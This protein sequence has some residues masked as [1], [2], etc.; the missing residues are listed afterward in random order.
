MGARFIGQKLTASPRAARACSAA[1]VIPLWCSTSIGIGHARQSTARI[2]CHQHR[3]W[4]CI[5]GLDPSRCAV[6]QCRITAGPPRSCGMSGRCSRCLW[7]RRESN[8][9][10]S[11]AISSLGNPSSPEKTSAEPVRDA[12]PLPTVSDDCERA[13]PKPASVSFNPSDVLRKALDEAIAKGD[14]EQAVKLARVLA[15]LA[16]TPKPRNVV[17]IA[18]ARKS[19]R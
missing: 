13:K 12:T 16:P 17:D 18:T 11:D 3:Y 19:R 6:L 4:M 5:D 15:T 9:A 8:L 7:R 2:E 1:G 10:E 14:E